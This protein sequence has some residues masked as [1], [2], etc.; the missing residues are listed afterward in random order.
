MITMIDRGRSAVSFL[1]PVSVLFIKKNTNL[2][3][4]LMW[5]YIIE[6]VNSQYF[7]TLSELTV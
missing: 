4:K 1:I 5:F 6:I 3:F 2:P 7:A